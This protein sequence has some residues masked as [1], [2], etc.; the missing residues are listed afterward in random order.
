MH[1]GI[2]CL[3]NDAQMFFTQEGLSATNCDKHLL[4]GNITKPCKF[5]G[6]KG[7]TASIR[8]G[9]CFNYRALCPKVI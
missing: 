5:A 9:W 7:K 4:A 1:M 3:L 8:P 2:Q 6:K